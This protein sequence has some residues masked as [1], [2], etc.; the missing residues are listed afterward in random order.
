MNTLPLLVLSL[1]ALFGTTQ[2]RLQTDIEYGKTGGVRLLLDASVPE[3]PGPF[4]IAIIIHG[5]GWDS[6]DKQHGITGLFEP[7]T[8]AHFSWF[9]IN[10]RLAPQHR[11]PASSEDVQQAIRWISANA[12]RFRG[13]PQRIALIGYSA[14]GHLATFAAVRAAPGTSVAA[15]VGLAAPTDLLADAERRGELSTS[16]KHLFDRQVFDDETRKILHDA[17]PINYV[18]PNLPP[19]LLIHGTADKSVPYAQSQ[20]FQARLKSAGVSCELITIES[21]S[22]NISEW[23]RLDPNYKEKMVAW[24]ARTLGRTE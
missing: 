4:P 21:A 16:M 12:A 17:S 5:G 22:H 19:V 11:Y 8:R 6:G 15:V 2:S 3:G 18:K 13:D 9:S 24:L 14:G 23:E 10:Y 1:A 20:N 7:L